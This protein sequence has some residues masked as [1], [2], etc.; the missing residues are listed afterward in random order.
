MIKIEKANMATE[1]NTLLDA[2]ILVEEACKPLYECI[3]GGLDLLLLHLRL[4]R[5][6]R[7]CG[8]RL[9]RASDND[10]HQ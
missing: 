1:Y 4:L 9:R 3:D 6:Y 5:G 7:F 8:T 10:R 2:S